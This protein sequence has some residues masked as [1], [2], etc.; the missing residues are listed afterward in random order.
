[1]GVD[2]AG[3]IGSGGCLR[4]G[5]GRVGGGE[6]PARQPRSVL[7]VRALDPDSGVPKGPSLVPIMFL[8]S[9]R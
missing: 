8:A 7:W 1:M 6:E 3:R 5:G 9:L 4:E 2:G